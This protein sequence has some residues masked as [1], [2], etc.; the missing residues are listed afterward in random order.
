[1]N[2]ITSPS[3]TL[4]QEVRVALDGSISQD[5]HEKFAKFVKYLF[6]RPDELEKLWQLRLQNPAVFRETVFRLWGAFWSHPG[7]SSQFILACIGGGIIVGTALIWG[8]SVSFDG[9][10]GNSTRQA[11]LI[12]DVLQ[13]EFGRR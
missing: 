10:A 8:F 9:F 7:E 12:T 1:M 4:I 11:P 2:N 3:Q 5:Q 13:V 6:N